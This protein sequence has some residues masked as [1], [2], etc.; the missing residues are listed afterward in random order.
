MLRA[1]CKHRMHALEL[2]LRAFNS[3]VIF[4]TTWQSTRPGAFDFDFEFSLPSPFFSFQIYQL[5]RAT[6]GG[7]RL[8]LDFVG[9]VRASCNMSCLRNFV[10]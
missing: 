4:F 6:S 10:E 5:S 2:I 9:H 1:C 8:R 3:R 7:R